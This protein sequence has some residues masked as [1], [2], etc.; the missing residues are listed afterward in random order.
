MNRG[1]PTVGITLDRKGEYL[2]LK[3][4]YATAIVR[5]GATVMLL[6]DENDPLS[7]A[8]QIDGLLIPGGPDIDPAYFSE[9][10][11][12]ATRIG[13]RERT[14]FE[15]RLLR[16]IMEL[17]KPVLGICYGMQLINVALGGSLYQDIAD[18]FGVSVDHTRGRHRIRG[19]IGMTK[20]EAW[21]NTSHHQGIKE[22]GER[23]EA[24]AVSDD[25]LV[26]AVRLPG[27]P[28]LMAVQ[29]HPEREDSELSSKIFKSFLEA[30][31]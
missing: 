31:L 4:H 12:P 24:S 23:L 15:I 28:Y 18:E 8:R 1:R 3:H 16:A 7:V 11:H 21:V 13:A 30:C 6:P 9:P 20:G 17:G 5:A 25:G 19:E 26:E 2:R 27:Y 10:A 22:L 14:G 29:W